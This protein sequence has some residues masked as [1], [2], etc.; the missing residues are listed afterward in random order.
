MMIL[1]SVCGIF[2]DTGAEAD[3]PFIKLVARPGFLRRLRKLEKKLKV[4]PEDCAVCEGELRSAATVVLSAKRIHHCAS[5]L[6]LDAAG[7]VLNK[8]KENAS[9]HEDISAFEK[10][11]VNAHEAAKRLP[12]RV[13]ATDQMGPKRKKG[14]SV[15]EGRRGEEVSVEER[16]LQWY[17]DVHHFRGQVQRL[18]W[19]EPTS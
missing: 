14:K 19:F 13:Y 16:A 12:G 9:A 11:Y 4:P 5:S 6:Q 18:P 2:R 15:W 1:I 3:F 8:D 7:N 17:E 10:F